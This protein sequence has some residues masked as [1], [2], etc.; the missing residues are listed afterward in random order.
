[1]SKLPFNHLESIQETQLELFNNDPIKRRHPRP[2]TGYHPKPSKPKK[3]IGNK[4]HQ[5]K[6]YSYAI[7]HPIVADYMG[8]GG[9]ALDVSMIDKLESGVW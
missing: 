6:K 1:M 5:S 2:P 4:H 9:S 3:Y 7:W 8:G